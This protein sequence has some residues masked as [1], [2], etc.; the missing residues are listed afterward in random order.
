MKLYN[1]ITEIISNVLG[2]SNEAIV[3]SSADGLHVLDSDTDVIKFAHTFKVFDSI[4]EPFNMD[5]AHFQL[6]RLPDEGHPGYSN[7]RIISLDMRFLGDKVNKYTYKDLKDGIVYL[8]NNVKELVNMKVLGHGSDTSIDYKSHGPAYTHAFGAQTSELVFKPDTTE[9]PVLPKPEALELCID[10]SQKHSLCTHLFQHVQTRLGLNKAEEKNDIK[11]DHSFIYVMDLTEFHL[12]TI[13]KACGTS[14]PLVNLHQNEA[15]YDNKIGNII[16]N[17]RNESQ[18]IIVGSTA[19][20]LGTAIDRQYKHLSSSDTDIILISSDFK[21]YE[22]I[23]EK[24]IVK[25]YPI[26]NHVLRLPDK[27]CPGRQIANRGFQWTNRKRSY[28]WP[29]EE[30]FDDIIKSGYFLAGVGSKES[31]ESEIQWRVSFNSAEQIIN[32][33]LIDQDPYKTIEE[34]EQLKEEGHVVGGYNTFIL[35]WERCW[36]D[37]TFMPAEPTVLPKPAALE[38]CID[39]SQKKI[40]FHPFLY[41]LLL[42]FLW[43]V[44]NDS[45]NREKEKVLEKMKNCVSRISGAEQSRGLNFIT[46]CCSIQTDHCSASRY[47]IQSFK[48][49]PVKQNVAYLYMQYIINLLRKCSSNRDLVYSF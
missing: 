25:P 4:R 1:K 22:H 34:F 9:L 17:F 6:I 31:E 36:F 13:L 14:L 32:K 11:T 7:L 43:H 19:E 47:L 26:L 41:G 49:N 21:V 40:S 29:T 44:K 10:N 12:P 42:E 48:L 16:D 38:L 45:K 28:N 46:Y 5:Y 39:N 15:N 3:A 37:V 35:V 27:T 18:A 20:G 24:D 30:L 23:N 33:D 2:T 8:K